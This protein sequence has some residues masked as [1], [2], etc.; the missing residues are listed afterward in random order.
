MRRQ[1]DGRFSTRSRLERT[2]AA[3][4]DA[5]ETRPWGWSRPCQSAASAPG[6]RGLRA[7]RKCRQRGGPF[8][9]DGPGLFPV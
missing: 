4:E 7:I 9:T 5:D 2:G 6:G 8:L 3:A 1:T